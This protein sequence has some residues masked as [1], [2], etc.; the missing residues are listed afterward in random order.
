METAMIE[1]SGSSICAEE[2]QAETGNDSSAPPAN[3]KRHAG[4]WRQVSEI[5]DE[6]GNWLGQA[7][8]SGRSGNVSG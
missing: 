4:L 7:R 6:P 2:V 5:N 8:T 1:N 3:R